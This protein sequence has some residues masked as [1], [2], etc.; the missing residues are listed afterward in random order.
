MK[1]RLSMPTI[2]IIVPVYNVEKY[3]RKCINSILNQTFSDFELILVDDESPDNCPQ[4]CDEYA[5]KDSRI[6]VIH[7][8]NGGVSAARN[9]GLEIVQGD[10]VAFCD[11]DDYVAED[12]LQKMHDT[13]IKTDADCV[14]IQF[15]LINDSGE[16]ISK[17]TYKTNEWNFR[18]CKDNVEYIVNELLR[19]KCGW[20]LWSHLYKISV[21]KKNKIKICETCSNFAEDLNFTLKYSLHC[22]KIIILQDCCYFYVQHEGS[23]MSNSKNMIKLD[24]MNEVSKDFGSYFFSQKFPRKINKF[25]PII[26]YFIMYEQYRTLLYYPVDYDRLELE[27]SK[28]NNKKWF[29]KY[30]NKIILQYGLLK[31]LFGKTNAQKIAVFSRFLFHQNRFIYKYE[32]AIYYKF[33]FKE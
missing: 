29:R 18:S 26:H 33:I 14:G 20:A 4:I 11:S 7:K 15:A 24:A 2:S 23:M 30:N 31:K 8:K 3:L 13:I 27:L 12:W 5:V 22:K 9:S 1:W 16:L 6:K 10:Y 17:S 32:R 19:G 21:I 28:I 25:F